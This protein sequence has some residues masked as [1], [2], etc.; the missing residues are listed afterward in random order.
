LFI[1]KLAN[2]KIMT[3]KIF[4]AIVACLLG[5]Q[6]ANA[7]I[8]R[9]TDDWTKKTNTSSTFIK[10]NTDDWAKK[11][12]T[13]STL[14]GNAISDEGPTADP[15]VPVGDALWIA[16]LLAGGYVLTKRCANYIRQSSL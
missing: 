2:L 4:L 11:T 12:N 13:S 5:F 14:R 10:R 16:V 9:N 1:S 15:N 3:T 8:K 7:D 6:T